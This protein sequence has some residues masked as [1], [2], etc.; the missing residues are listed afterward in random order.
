MGSSDV[1]AGHSLAPARGGETPAG[2][3][4]LCV[5]DGMGW[6][7]RD[8]GDAVY[9][10]DTPHLDRLIA[11]APNRLLSAHGTAVGLPSDEDMGNSEVGHNALG[12]GRI[13]DQGAKLV[14]QAIQTGSIFTGGL[15]A[16]LRQTR[17]LHLIGLLSDGN[18]HSHIDQLFALI[19]RAHRDG[20]VH[21]RVHV[22]TDGRDVTERSALDYLRP[23]E[24]LLAACAAE[25]ADYAVASGGGRMGITMDRYEADWSMVKRGW[26]CHVHGVGRPFSSASQAVETLYKEDPS[27][28]D[29][30][31]PAFVVVNADGEPKGRI[32][33][34]DGVVFFNFRGDRALEITQAFENRHLPSDFDRCG[35]GG[36]PAPEV[37]YAG[38]MQYDGDLLL[39]NRYLVEPP[40]I[41]RTLGEFLTAAQIP[42]FAIAETHK[43]GHVTY[44]FNGNNSQ[45][46]DRKLETWREITSRP[47]AVDAAPEM[48]A[49]EVAE[50][51][52]EAIRSGQY[53]HVRLNYANGD[54]VG[55]TGDF[56][57]TVRAVEIVDEC[58]GRLVRDVRDTGGVLLLTADHGNA[59]Q[60][61]E[62]DKRT[63]DYKTLTTGR[64]QAKTSHTLNPVPFVLLDPS[65]RLQLDTSS[66]AGL[67]NVAA[68]VLLASGLQPPD[69]YL[70]S[71]V[72]FTT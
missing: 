45:P 67:G 38:L 65:G 18:V 24:E 34:G 55:H 43:F 39:P 68:A 13:F 32:R 29:Q 47:G 49:R 21:L 3:V 61:F 17:C 33:D 9:V 7:R 20:I 1:N 46:F 37:L 52:S 28:N 56:E 5:L 14:D 62:I 66:P 63:R 59:D 41:D 27:V 31:L 19:R 54:M 58:V 12:A 6:G 36:E 70:P 2:P 50:A 71:L 30:F 25:G 22:L 69:D 11:T 42:S 57:A 44:F 40:A 64:R 51:T 4:V 72:S 35:P 48:R 60:M 26:D 10:A 53:G 16:E 23:L 15:W 8:D